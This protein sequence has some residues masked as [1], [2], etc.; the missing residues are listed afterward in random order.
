MLNNLGNAAR[1]FTALG[2]ERSLAALL[3][4]GTMAPIAPRNRIA[5]SSGTVPVRSAALDTCAPLEG[6]QECS[7]LQSL[8]LIQF[9]ASGSETITRL[10]LGPSAFRYPTGAQLG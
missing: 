7:P 10:P 9:S 8:H 4:H 3:G 1:Q 5:A 6:R 2:N